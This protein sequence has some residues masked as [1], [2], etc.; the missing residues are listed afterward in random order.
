M[1]QLQV[2]PR[3]IEIVKMIAEGMSTRQISF[4]L[5]ISEHTVHAHRRNIL[6]KLGVKNMAHLVHYTW[7]KGW[8]GTASRAVL[9]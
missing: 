7:Q 9:S 2:T 6:T 4:Q 1:E 3:E 5:F 8:F